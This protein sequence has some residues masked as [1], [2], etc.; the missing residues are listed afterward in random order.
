[1]KILPSWL[2]E[3]V[4]V[5]A[6]DG[7]LAGA[8]TQAGVNIEGISQEQGQTVFEAEITPNRPD[9]MNHYG[10]ARECSAIFDR[11]LKPL[12]AKLPPAKG[13][14]PKAKGFSI[15]I[16]DAAGCARYTARVIRDVKTGPSPAPV[17]RRL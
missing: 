4:D 5:P 12:S 1:M 7:E 11:D 3:F 9:A 8:L 13:Q 17:Q 6:D 16:D 10:V 14:Q 15:I 2:R